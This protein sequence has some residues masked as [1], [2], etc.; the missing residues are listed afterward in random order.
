MNTHFLPPT[1]NLL[2][3]LILQTSEG[4]RAIAPAEILYLESCRNYTFVYLSDGSRMITS[5]NLG[6]FEIPFENHGFVRI[7]KS[8]IANLSYIQD[9]TKENGYSIQLP[10]GQWQKCSR[11]RISAVKKSLK[12]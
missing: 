5:K 4:K 12:K 1:T 9:S 7:N 8:I 2:P 3:R 11:R 10:N 6:T